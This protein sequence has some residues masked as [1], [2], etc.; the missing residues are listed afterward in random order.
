M[1]FYKILRFYHTIS[2]WSIFTFLVRFSDGD[3]SCACGVFL[4]QLC[5]EHELSFGVASSQLISFG[6][7]FPWSVSLYL[8]W[9]NFWYH[10]CQWHF[11]RWVVDKVDLP[12]GSQHY[13]ILFL[14]LSSHHTC[15]DLFPSFVTLEP[16]QS[17]RMYGSL[18]L[19]LDC[20][21]ACS[22][23]R[24]FDSLNSLAGT[25][26]HPFVGWCQQFFWLAQCHHVGPIAVELFRHQVMAILHFQ[27]QF[28]RNLDDGMS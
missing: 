3:V 7:T 1:Y 28:G 9:S 20:S 14:V 16:S 8:G 18:V 27:L 19:C 12:S 17:K 10:P 2:E 13:S 25:I 26:D 23:L 4:R 11:L 6:N 15:V 22:R 24:L 21:S 5:D